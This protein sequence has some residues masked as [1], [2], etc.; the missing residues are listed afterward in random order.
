MTVALYRQEF[1]SDS[2]L[3]PEVQQFYCGD[4][5]WQTDVA[6]FLKSTNGA[7]REVIG[8]NYLDRT[9]VWLFWRDKDKQLL[10]GYGSLYIHLLPAQVPQPPTFHWVIPYLGVA[11][12]HQQN[13]NGAKILRAL[14]REASEFDWVQPIVHVKVHERNTHGLRFFEKWGFRRSPSMA[15]GDGEPRYYQLSLA[16]PRSLD[17]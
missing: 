17:F 8:T 11:A 15:G 7:R 4:S 10:V 14:I 13:S 1:E 9:M 2:Y 3:L 16:F 5:P 6:N 12:E